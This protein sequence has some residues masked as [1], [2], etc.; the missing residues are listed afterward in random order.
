MTRRL[1]AFGVIATLV[2]VGYADLSACGD[3]F[4][5]PG[6][7]ARIRGYA[8]VHPASI[9]ILRPPSAKPADL[10][11]FQRILKQAGHT[12]L[13]VDRRDELLQTVADGTRDLVFAAYAEAQTIEASLASVPSRPHVVPL[14]YKASDATIAE[15]RQ[16]F[17]ALIETSKMDRY[18]A[19]EEIERLMKTR[20]QNMAAALPR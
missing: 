6:R 7:S 18:Q 2:V 17:H 14:L 9:V 8:A 12:S 10:K 4:L 19:L 5:R 20:P 13:V 11:S 15:A 3:K 1:F 16:H